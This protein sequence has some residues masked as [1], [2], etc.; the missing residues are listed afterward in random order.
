VR[1][2]SAKRFVL[3][4]AG[5]SI[6]ASPAA[7]A[8]MGAVK[9]VRLR[10]GDPLERLRTEG[11]QITASGQDG[12]SQRA[13]L[14]WVALASGAMLVVV[15][16]AIQSKRPLRLARV[17]VQ[18]SEGGEQ[19]RRK[20]NDRQVGSEAQQ[21]GTAEEVSAEE[22]FAELGQHVATVLET[23]RAA[24]ER[25]EGDARRD[26]T[27]LL[28][29]SQAEAEETLAEARR[30]A[31]ELEAEAAQARSEAGRAA[32][33]VRARTETYIEEK[34]QEADDAAAELLARA[35]RQARERARAAEERQQ[36]LDAN[37]ERTEER[38]RKLVIGLRELAGRLDVLV[39]SDA[40]VDLAE[41]EYEAPQAAGLEE[42][43]RRQVGATEASDAVPSI[44][45][46][47]GRE[48]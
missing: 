45:E 31:E 5:V 41:H 18:S 39:G 15:G 44:A 42:E 32:E 30:K 3:A 43:L 13:R 26:A 25:I 14:I 10:S 17:G 9:P 40:L 37:V 21:T 27:H 28:E 4:V 34:Q 7:G 8:A 2:V 29:R 38:L 46:P 1:E 48:A 20:S 47:N 33:D 11:S 24:A 6:L 23:A 16:S 12:A 36:V 35:E 22:S 19:M